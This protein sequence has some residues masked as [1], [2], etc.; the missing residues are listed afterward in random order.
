M[1][2]IGRKGVKLKVSQRP[3]AFFD[4]FE[5]S[6]ANLVAATDQLRNML[7]EYEDVEMKA[8]RIAEREHDGD[9]VTHAIIRLLNTT[10]V[11]PMDREDI[12]L[13]GSALDDVLD[14]VEA[15]SDLFNLQLLHSLRQSCDC[16]VLK[17]AAHGKVN[18]KRFAHS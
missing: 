14:S 2:S 10:F 6:G 8:R 5:E 7:H 18:S 15:V 16:R 1:T 4:L 12:Y 9:E 3:E 11:T 13:L 17:D